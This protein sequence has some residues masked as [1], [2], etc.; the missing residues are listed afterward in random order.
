MLECEIAVARNVADRSRQPRARREAAPP[1]ARP[2]RHL[3]PLL[4]P[5]RSVDRAPA[6]MVAVQQEV[7]RKPKPALESDVEGAVQRRDK[8]RP[9]AGR[10]PVDARRD[11]AVAASEVIV[12]NLEFPLEPVQRQWVEIAQHGFAGKP[13]GRSPEPDRRQHRRQVTAIGRAGPSEGDAGLGHLALQWSSRR[14]LGDAR[15]SANVTSASARRPSGKPAR[16][17]SA[18]ACLAGSPRIKRPSTAKPKLGP[19]NGSSTSGRRAGIRVRTASASCPRRSV[20]PF[21][22]SM[23]TATPG[24]LSSAR[25]TVQSRSSRCKTACST[26]EGL[27]PGAAQRLRSS[28]HRQVLII[29]CWSRVTGNQVVCLK[30]GSRDR[31]R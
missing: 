17:R 4:S 20:S 7:G 10:D 5:S 13:A 26:A 19:T 8:T 12:P 16:A 27:Q 11:D 28:G 9:S 14:R 21:P 31:T 15:T 23:R 30:P 3:K 22:A 6:G 18:I 29:R 2:R 24:R 1:A 25:K